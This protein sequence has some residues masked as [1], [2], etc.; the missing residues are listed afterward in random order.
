MS[1]A[2]RQAAEKLAKKYNTAFHM[3]FGM[4]LGAVMVFWLQA[5][6]PL[7]SYAEDQFPLPVFPWF[8]ASVAA[9]LSVRL[10]PEAYF[11]IKSPAHTR[12]LQE[13]LGIRWLRTVITDGDLV[14]RRVRQS[15]PGYIVADAFTSWHKRAN[16]S[17]DIERAHLGFLLFGA[18]ASVCALAGG[19][20]IT[21]LLICLGNVAVNLLPIFLQRYTRARVELLL[22]R[23]PVCSQNEAESLG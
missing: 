18:G 14:T 17:R 16:I 13:A 12:R 8:L 3:L 5:W 10:F 15:Y 6:G 23:R 1:P 9:G 21:A 19:W 7:R 22:E 4:W 20:G 2:D 11:T